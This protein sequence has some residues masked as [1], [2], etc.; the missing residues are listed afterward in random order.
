MALEVSRGTV[1]SE[2]MCLLA[3]PSITTNVFTATLAAGYIGA[4][5]WNTLLV[6]GCEG[7]AQSKGIIRDSEQQ[8]LHYMD[9]RELMSP[10]LAIH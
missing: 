7:C 4:G 6:F 8:S 2:G 10:E 3:R 1:K 5:R 9:G